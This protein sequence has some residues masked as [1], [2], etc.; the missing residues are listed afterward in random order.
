[1]G[2]LY[3]QRGSGLVVPDNSITL[4]KLADIATARFLGRTTAGSGDPEELTA[5][6]ATAMLNA[7]TDALKGLVPA[8]GGGTSNFLRADGSWAAPGGG[9][10]PWTV[11]TCSGDSAVTSATVPV[12]V[13]GISF[14]AEANKTYVVEGYMIVDTGNAGVGVR[15]GW[16]AS[17]AVTNLLTQF[18]HPSTNAGGASMGHSIT[19]DGT[20]GT[21]SAFAS[22]NTKYL[23]R[24]STILVNGGSSNTLQL[25]ITGEAATATVT[26][27]AGSVALY[28]KTN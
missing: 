17:A 12:D 5:T 14:T 6:Q 7:F 11:L 8:S 13:T 16:N 3:V 15:L 1:M 28:R 22:A 10:D 25:R 19:D 4:A 27:Y 24:F 26:A 18:W 9:S 2:Q 21:T 23:V 20:E